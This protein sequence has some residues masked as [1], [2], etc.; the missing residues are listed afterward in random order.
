M[1]S[2]FRYRVAD[3]RLCTFDEQPHLKKEIKR[4]QKFVSQKPDGYCSACMRV[5]YP[6]ERKYR[7]VEDPANLPCVDWK[8]PALVHPKDKRMYMFCNKHYNID[9]SDLPRFRYPGLF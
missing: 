2:F 7:Y 9:E 8:L 3:K 4:F 1:T 5:L 6:E